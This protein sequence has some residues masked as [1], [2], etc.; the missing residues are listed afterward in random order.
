MQCQEP[1]QERTLARPY[2]NQI[3]QTSEYHPT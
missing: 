3:D 2:I 1:G